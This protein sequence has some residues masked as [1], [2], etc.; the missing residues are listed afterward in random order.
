MKNIINI[1]LF[2]LFFV[3]L[4]FWVLIFMLSFGMLVRSLDSASVL[5]GYTGY[6]ILIAGFSIAN[7]VPIAKALRNK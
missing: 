1:I 5:K 6:C 7:I 2:V 3:L 4:A